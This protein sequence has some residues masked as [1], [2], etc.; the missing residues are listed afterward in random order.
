VSW[1]CALTSLGTR[2]GL[3][4]QSLARPMGRSDCVLRNCSRPFRLRQPDFTMQNASLYLRGC[5][6]DHAI[7]IDTPPFR[8]TI[9]IATASVAV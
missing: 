4:R 3:G 1:L 8:L 2:G 6:I 9:P 5:H 7:A